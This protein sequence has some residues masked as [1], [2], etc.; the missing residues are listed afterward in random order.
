MAKKSK[1]TEPVAVSEFQLTGGAKIIGYE[2]GSF[3]FFP[4]PIEISAENVAAIFGGEPDSDSDEDEE[5]GVSIEDMK[6]AL[7]ESGLTKKKVNKMS[8]EEVEEAYGELET[9]EDEDEEE[10]S[11]EDEDEEDSDD[12]DEVSIED[13]KAA[14]I[15]S[16]MA[17]KK[18]NKMS[19]EEIE[20]AYGELEGDDDSDEEDD[21]EDSD[22]DD[23]SD[24][25]DE[26]DDDEDSDDE[27]EEDEEE[28]TGD[29]LAEMDFE[30]I[31]DVCDEK[32]LDTDPDDFE[33]VEKLRAAVAK[34]LGI[35]LPKK[36]KGK[37]GK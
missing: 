20:E 2:D 14:L 15:E 1:A 8:D 27:D 28:L 12:E 24:D 17:K 21:D 35:S 5:E 31:E 33:D 10:D 25:S 9:E 37:K 22:D 29:A 16:G 18:V 34:E 4:A 32:D 6:A 13:M 30:E 11:D 7:I 23:D 36:A 3:K 26:E 19:D